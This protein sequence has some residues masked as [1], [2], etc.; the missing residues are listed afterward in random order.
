MR[1]W[2]YENRENSLESHSSGC[3]EALLGFI[4][5]HGQIL[6]EQKAS[7]AATIRTKVFLTVLSGYCQGYVPT[8]AGLH[9]RCEKFVHF[10]SVT[11]I[12]YALLW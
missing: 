5:D 2:R 8:T 10:I 9:I 11:T 1:T 12:I 4:Q 3:G 6:R 7:L